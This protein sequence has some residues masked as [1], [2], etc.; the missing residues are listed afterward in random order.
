M[1]KLAG[2]MNVKKLCRIENTANHGE[3]DS[4]FLSHSLVYLPLFILSGST[5]GDIRYLPHLTLGNLL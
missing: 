3:D 4:R 2:Q 5:S 1:Y